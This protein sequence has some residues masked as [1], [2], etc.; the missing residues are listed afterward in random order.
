MTYY[1]FDRMLLLVSGNPAR[2]LLGCTK[3]SIATSLRGSLSFD[4]P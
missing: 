2:E 3:R 4:S 1:L